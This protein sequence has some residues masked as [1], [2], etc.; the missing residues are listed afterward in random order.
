M[1]VAVLALRHVSPGAW[2]AT[3]ALALHIV[4]GAATYAA[5]VWFFHGHRF[6]AFLGLLREARR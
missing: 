5:V 1:A 4:T 3:L 6:R 2:P